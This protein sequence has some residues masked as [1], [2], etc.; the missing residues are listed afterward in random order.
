MKKLT[1][2]GRGVLV[3]PGIAWLKQGATVEVSNAVADALERVTPPLKITISAV[4]DGDS[5]SESQPEAHQ[6]EGQPTASTD[7]KE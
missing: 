1:H 7:P 4:D 5:D 2:D 6:G 3:L